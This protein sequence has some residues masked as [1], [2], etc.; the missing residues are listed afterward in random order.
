MKNINYPK[1]SSVV[2]LYMM[3][4]LVN[5][6]FGIMDLVFDANIIKADWHHALHHI[7]E[8]VYILFALGS[9]SYLWITYK[10]SLS[11]LKKSE[12]AAKNL[13]QDRDHWRGKHENLI[14]GMQSAIVTQLKKWQLSDSEIAVA[15]FLMRG[16]SH[17]QISGLLE[18]S[19]KT[20][21][22]QSLA[23]Y[24]KTGMNGRSE[25][26]AFFIEDIFAF[27]EID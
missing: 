11:L 7:L 27:D 22:N 13:L 23:I 17:K 24:K 5:I 20:V 14:N 4:M 18:K 8:I 3:F 1:E 6:L 19:E 25:L 2:S 15:L 9:T 16:Y 21:R 12:T 26:T 10:N